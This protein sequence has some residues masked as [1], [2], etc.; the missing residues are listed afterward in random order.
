MVRRCPRCGGLPKENVDPHVH[1]RT[2]YM[3]MV[4]VVF[5][6]KEHAV[7]RERP[8]LYGNVRKFFSP[9]GWSLR[10]AN[11]R[12]QDEGDAASQQEADP[13]G[14]DL[15]VIPSNRGIE[16]ILQRN[17]AINKRTAPEHH[18][19]PTEQSEGIAWMT[20]CLTQVVDRRHHIAVTIPLYALQ[21]CYLVWLALRAA[22]NSSPG[23]H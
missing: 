16:P 20:T 23:S 2:K 5:V 9:I 12:K 6:G 1:T 17:A 19:P 8:K 21:H 13:R 4:Q 10:G 11:R 15:F 3:H 18:A 7:G 14:P 22:S